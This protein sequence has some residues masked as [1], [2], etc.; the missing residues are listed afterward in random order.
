M[1][2]DPDIIYYSQLLSS[3]SHLSKFRSNSPNSSKR[4]F[5]IKLLDEFQ[6]QGYSER[7]SSKS[8]KQDDAGEVIMEPL[9]GFASLKGKQ[10]SGR[11]FQVNSA[12]QTLQDNS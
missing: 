11:P 7:H 1:S 5:R 3:S 12:S 2:H 10:I 4:K 8:L 6:L 9:V